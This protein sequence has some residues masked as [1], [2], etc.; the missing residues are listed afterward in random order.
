MSTEGLI[1]KFPTK[2]ASRCYGCGKALPIGEMVVG[3]KGAT[4]WKV[5][6]MGCGEQYLKDLKGS[7]KAS[8]PPS[9]EK[10]VD[11]EREVEMLKHLMGCKTAESII[12]ERERETTPEPPTPLTLAE[13]IKQG[14]TWRI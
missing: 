8:D 13:R 1:R 12:E 10:P 6:C 5:F 7:A 4:R 2:F 9:I 3:I 14:A 11:A